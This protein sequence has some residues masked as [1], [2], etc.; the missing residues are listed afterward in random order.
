M[1]VSA[2]QWQQH[3]REYFLRESI[4]KDGVTVAIA[5]HTFFGI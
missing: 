3:H 1:Y 5:M 4:A 2:L